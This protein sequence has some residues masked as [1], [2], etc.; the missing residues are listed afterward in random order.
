MGKKRTRRVCRALYALTIIVTVIATLGIIGSVLCL[1]HG[2]LW[3]ILPLAINI[4]FAWFA[5]ELAEA[6]EK[7][8]G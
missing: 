1:V 5:E 2:R 7:R 8:M 6:T 3:A 4:A